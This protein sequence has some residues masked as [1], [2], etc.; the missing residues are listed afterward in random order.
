[1]RS[2]ASAA[3]VLLDQIGEAA[4]GGEHRAV[5]FVVVKGD[6]EMVLQPGDEREHGHGVELGQVA[7][8][9]GAAVEAEGAA[10]QAERFVEHAQDLVCDVHGERCGERMAKGQGVHG[11]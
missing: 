8:Q 4:D 6:T 5:E 11:F 7:E 9:R 3:Q 10:L 1:M 2:C